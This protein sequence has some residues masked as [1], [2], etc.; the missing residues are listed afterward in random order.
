MRKA[1]SILNE[2]TEF[3]AEDIEKPKEEQSKLKAKAGQSKTKSYNLAFSL[4]KAF[5]K[6]I[7]GACRQSMVQPKLFL[8]QEVLIWFNKQHWR[9]QGIMLDTFSQCIND[10]EDDPFE[11]IEEIYSGLIAN[12]DLREKLTK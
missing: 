6:L 1:Y 8:S 11:Y 3:K 7:A 12:T 5:P 9:A 4:S 2:K 10:D